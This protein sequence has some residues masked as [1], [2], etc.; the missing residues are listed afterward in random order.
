MPRPDL[1]RARD[2]VR[3]F[4]R[5]HGLPYQETSLARAYMDLVINFAHVGKLV[6]RTEV[7][8][9]TR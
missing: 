1:P 3:A 9:Q 5:T 8:A 4:C 6:S 7:P 2:G